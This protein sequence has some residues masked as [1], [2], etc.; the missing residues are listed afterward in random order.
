M[1]TVRHNTFETNSSSSHS[2]TIVRTAEPSY[3]GLANPALV[4]G[5]MVLYPSRLN[6]H[7]KHE[8]GLYSSTWKLNASVTDTKAALLVHQLTNFFD[9]NFHEEWCADILPKVYDAIKDECGYTDIC[10]DDFYAN[11]YIGNAYG[12]E[13]KYPEDFPPLDFLGRTLSDKPIIDLD[14]LRTY[15]R[16]YITNQFI[17][18]VDTSENN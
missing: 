17:T 14:R 10:T 15:I 4:D 11:Y 12:D 18:I 5:G 2:I 13:T 3:I 8:G 16:E 9:D 7:V 1:K 6:E